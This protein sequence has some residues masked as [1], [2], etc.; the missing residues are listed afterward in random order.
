MVVDSG[1]DDSEVNAAASAIKERASQQG[2][3]MVYFQTKNPNFG[4]F[5]R[6]L[7]RKMLIYFTA[8]RNIFW[9]FGIS[10]DLL[11]QF[12]FIGYSFFRFLGSCIK[13]NLATLPRS[14]IPGTV[15]CRAQLVCNYRKFGA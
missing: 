6:A 7:D 4:K 12:L 5:L 9:P 15:S 13:K 11:V 1:C 3:Q 14:S 8:I 2:C 10:L